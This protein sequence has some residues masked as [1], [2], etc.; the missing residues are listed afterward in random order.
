VIFGDLRHHAGRMAEENRLRSPV[1]SSIRLSLTRGAT[2]STAP[3]EVSTCRGW[4]WPLRTTSLRPSASTSLTW[5]A[6]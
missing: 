5:A 1:I 3:A 6:M 4:A 2:T